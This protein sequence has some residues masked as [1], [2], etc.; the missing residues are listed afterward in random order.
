[1][2]YTL[3]SRAG[4]PNIAGR[5]RAFQYGLGE[6]VTRTASVL[7]AVRVSPGSG[8]APHAAHGMSRCNVSGAFAPWSYYHCRAQGRDRRPPLRSDASCTTR[9]RTSCMWSPRA[10]Q[11]PRVTCVG[12]IRCD[13]GTG[14]AAAITPPAGASQADELGLEMRRDEPWARV[15]TTQTPARIRGA[16]RLMRES[17]RADECAEP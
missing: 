8:A 16:C 1:M 6:T 13:G 2:S 14:A 7:P 3:D 15:D 10:P 11:P 4:T 12:P 17:P 9:T 5:L